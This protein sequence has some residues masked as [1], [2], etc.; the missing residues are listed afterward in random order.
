MPERARSPIEHRSARRRPHQQGTS[1]VVAF[2][3]MFL[4]LLEYVRPLDEIDELRPAHLEHLQKAYDRGIFLV[5][6]P[7]VP[8]TGAVMVAHDGDRADLEAVL[9]A[10]PYVTN[11]A[12]TYEIV[13]FTAGLA[14]PRIGAR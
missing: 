14:D 9:E 2:R 12:V 13:E 6:G 10:D 4:V 11:S 8:R 5:S 1:G 3:A 7:R